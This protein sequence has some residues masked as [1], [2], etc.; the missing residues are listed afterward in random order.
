MRAVIFGDHEYYDP[1]ASPIANLFDISTPDGREHF[2]LGILL[3]FAKLASTNSAEEGFVDTQKLYDYCQGL[4]FQPSQI[5]SAIERAR[6]KRLLEPGARFSDP[7]GTRN[8]RITTVGAYT[9]ESLVHY[10]QY[11]D[12][13]VVD[14][15]IVDEDTRTRIWDCQNIRERLE[16]TE[17][18]AAY[19]D[20]QWSPLAG[21][22]TVFDWRPISDSLRYGIQRIRNSL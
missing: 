2:L 10:V 9:A 7:L 3:T 14:T 18:F 15:P 21:K 8:Y 5:N 11:A 16:R 20:R 22:G 19:L 12:A 13:M 1:G 17:T 4:G 6:R